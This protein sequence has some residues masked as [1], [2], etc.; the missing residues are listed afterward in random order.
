MAK[1][2]RKLNKK[3]CKEDHSISDGD[4]TRCYFGRRIGSHLKYTMTAFGKCDRHPAPCNAYKS[5]AGSLPD[6]QADRTA[7]K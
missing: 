1:N 7:M 3:Y 6:S 2:F 4:C 5:H